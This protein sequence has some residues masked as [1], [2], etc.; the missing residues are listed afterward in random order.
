MPVSEPIS[1]GIHAPSHANLL[2]PAPHKWRHGIQHFEDFG[3]SAFVRQGHRCHRERE[4]DDGLLILRYLQP[5]DGVVY[6]GF[7]ERLLCFLFF[8]AALPVQLANLRL[9]YVLAEHV[10]LVYGLIDLV[11][12]VAH[13]LRDARA[14]RYE[15]R[16][17]KR[18][19]GLVL[20]KR[21]QRDVNRDVGVE[22]VV[23]RC[24]N[25]EREMLPMP[26]RQP[27]RGPR[28]RTCTGLRSCLTGLQGSTWARWRGG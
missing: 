1:T 17:C 2:L 23:A 15:I 12:T 28:R 10:R 11:S 18:V 20:T 4:F 24:E 14:E 6:L 21:L 8:P 5:L 22:A 16:L 13:V 25:R 9:V 27:S 19:L 7:D 26:S 3:A